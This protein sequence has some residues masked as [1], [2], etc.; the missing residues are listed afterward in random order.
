MSAAPRF[1]DARVY[2]AAPGFLSHLLGELGEVELGR[3]GAQHRGAQLGGVAEA[4][5]EEGRRRQH[6]GGQRQLAAD[7]RQRLLQAVGGGAV[8]VQGPAEGQ[9]EADALALQR[10]SI[11][12]R[13]LVGMAAAPAL[14]HGTGKLAQPRPKSRTPATGWPQAFAQV[15][16]EVS[17]LRF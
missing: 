15:R 5:H 16:I 17:V 6:L 3:F 1:L 12:D 13:E 4:H 11:G 14:V 7:D 9:D 8:T 10:G 2:H